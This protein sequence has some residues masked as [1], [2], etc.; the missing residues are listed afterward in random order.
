MF[1]SL[2]HIRI[3]YKGSPDPN[4]DYLIDIV[5]QVKAIALVTGDKALLKW[6]DS[7]IQIV[8]WKDFQLSYPI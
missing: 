8:S 4:D 1:I 7:P 5:Q 3:K 2:H 6:K